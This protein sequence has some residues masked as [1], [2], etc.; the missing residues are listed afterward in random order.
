VIAVHAAPRASKDAIAGTHGD[1]LKV[2]LN[3]P[4]V[5][6]KANDRL[7]K[8]LAEKLGVPSAALT[9]LRG[10][11]SREKQVLVS[12]LAAAEIRARLLAE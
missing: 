1:A 10:Q 12:G 5:D 3:A 6:G 4:P 11:S 9:L 2:R 8:F 7:L